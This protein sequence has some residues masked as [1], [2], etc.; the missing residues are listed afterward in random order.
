MCQTDEDLPVNEQN[1]QLSETHGEW[2]ITKPSK[3][4]ES[5]PILLSTDIFKTA[6]F[7]YSIFLKTMPILIFPL[8][9]LAQLYIS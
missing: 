1:S 9:I 6:P 3:P 7:I 8:K 5:L 2:I 4:G